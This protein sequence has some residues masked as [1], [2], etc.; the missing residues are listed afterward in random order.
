MDLLD[1]MRASSSTMKCVD[2]SCCIATFTHLRSA[3]SITDILGQRQDSKFLEALHDCML[4]NVAWRALPKECGPWSSVWKRF[5][6][7]REASVFETLAGF[8]RTAHFVGMFDS[9]VLRAHVSAAGAKGASVPG[10]RPFAWRLLDQNTPQERL[11]GRASRLPYDR[12]RSGRQPVF[13]LLLDIGPDVK[14]RAAL[15]FN[16][17]LVESVHTS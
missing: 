17:I 4:H 5:W 10:A 8:S 12:R 6:R 1:G 7:L 14:P 3:S 2:D 16:F 9:T 13:G 11:R 15:A